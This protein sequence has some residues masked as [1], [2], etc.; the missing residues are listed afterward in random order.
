VQKYNRGPA[1]TFVLH[2]LTTKLEGG[3]VTG[4]E[5][6]KGKGDGRSRR[7]DPVE[8]EKMTVVLAP[9]FLAG[10]GTSGAATLP[11]LEC[12]RSPATLPHGPS[13]Y[14]CV[15]IRTV[16]D[17]V[18]ERANLEPAT[19]SRKMGPVIPTAQQ[20]ALMGRYPLANV[21]YAVPTHI[22]SEGQTPSGLPTIDMPWG[23]GEV[24][25]PT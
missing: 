11:K 22:L 3:E 8:E 19:P 25:Q 4:S 21:R 6:E 20:V 16:T 14:R 12:R 2:T 1:E 10:A 9:W 23:A 5:G 15:I 17:C 18:R 13:R 7:P 24:P